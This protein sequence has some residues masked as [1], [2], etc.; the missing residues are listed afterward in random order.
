M[1]GLLPNQSRVQSLSQYT[2]S[3]TKTLDKKSIKILSSAFTKKS[4]NQSNPNLNAAQEINKDKKGGSKLQ[5]IPNKKYKLQQSPAGGGVGTSSGTKVA[6]DRQGAPA[7]DANTNAEASQN[8]YG[9]DSPSSD[10]YRTTKAAANRAKNAAQLDDG[11]IGAED[12][13]VK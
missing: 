11:N 8:A 6:A 5:L 10:Y 9:G 1:T 12:T 7:S 3:T 13:V 4:V 2:S